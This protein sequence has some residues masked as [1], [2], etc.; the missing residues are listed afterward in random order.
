MWYIHT[1]EYYSAIKREVLPFETMWVD[2]EN[3]MLSK[4]SHM[5]KDKYHTISLICGI[6][7]NFV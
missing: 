7:K 4:I 2:L 3:I 5:E 6:Y 1:T